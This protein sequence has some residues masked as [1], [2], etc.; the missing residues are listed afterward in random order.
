M[1]GRW[2]RVLVAVLASAIAV[3]TAVAATNSGETDLERSIKA[4]FLYK[5]LN[6]ADWPPTAFTDANAPF[7]IGIYGEDAMAD[8]LAQLAVGRT[9][10]GRAVD[11]RKLR[12]GD[13]LAGIHVLFVST[14]ETSQ[15]P[16]L[17][18]AAVRQPMLIVSEGDGAL[19][20]GSAINLLV[21][22]GRVRF[23][24]SLDAAEKSG[25]HLSSRL[26]SVARTVRSRGEP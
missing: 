15:L 13:S 1:R 11:V 7:V 2:L 25:V 4:V 5:F 22:D 14:D 12:R 20:A 9:V 6:Y 23:D 24:I 8:D 17:A 26:L 18:R 3:S 16:V 21:V 10:S 19:G